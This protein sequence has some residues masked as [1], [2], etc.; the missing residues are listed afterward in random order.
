MSAPKQR[1]LQLARLACDA[2]AAEGEARNAAIAACRLITAKPE[3]LVGVEPPCAPPPVG[4]P[5]E[6]VVRRVIS[7]KF[8]GFCQRC[9][10][11]HDV[12]KPVAWAKGHGAICARCHVR[13]RA[14]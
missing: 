3:I 11:W 13:S 4:A 8:A 12:G 5:C 14:S 1:I 9:A 2:G 6:S 7:S 10:T